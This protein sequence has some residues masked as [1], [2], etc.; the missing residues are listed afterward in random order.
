MAALA[1]TG[2]E[3]AIGVYPLA[4]DICSASQNPPCGQSPGGPGCHAGT[5]YAPVPVCQAQGT[6][7][8]GGG[9]TTVVFWP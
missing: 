8:Q 7:K 1:A 2:N 9:S 6:V 3:N 4:C 5:Q